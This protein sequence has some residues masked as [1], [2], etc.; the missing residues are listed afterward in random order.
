MCANFFERQTHKSPPTGLNK[1]HA[2]DL[3]FTGPHSLRKES[4]F[5]HSALLNENAAEEILLN[6]ILL[7]LIF[8]YRIIVLISAGLGQ[9]VRLLA[10]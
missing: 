3:H 4:A 10:V 8:I 5:L 1:K 9:A 7:T 2:L 6:R